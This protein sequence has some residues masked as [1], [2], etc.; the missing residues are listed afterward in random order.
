MQWQWTLESIEL[1]EKNTQI[2]A[3]CSYRCSNLRF[4]CPFR[5]RAESAPFWLA[6]VPFTRL[7]G[8]YG[9]NRHAIFILLGRQTHR[10]AIT[11]EMSTKYTLTPKQDSHTR[12]FNT[13]DGM[14]FY[15]RKICMSSHVY[16]GPSLS[17]QVKMMIGWCVRHG[18]PKMAQFRTH[19]LTKERA[20]VSTQQSGYFPMD[21]ETIQ[22]K[23][24]QLAWTLSSHVCTFLR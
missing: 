19:Y 18:E 24:V 11:H 7:M 9:H 15:G 6:K 3:C 10:P 20:Y 22:K 1:R 14:I 12:P 13:T 2:I 23:C 8:C 5:P 16:P 17:V 4:S 21:T